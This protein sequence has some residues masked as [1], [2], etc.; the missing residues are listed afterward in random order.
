MGVSFIREETFI[1]SESN[2]SIQEGV[3]ISSGDP[4]LQSQSEIIRP[5][6][7]GYQPMKSQSQPSSLHGT[8]YASSESGSRPGSA[9]K[10]WIVENEVLYHSQDVQATCTFSL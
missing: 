7:T 2:M 4:L 8:P 9:R 1:V 6:K 3:V 5:W 10:Q